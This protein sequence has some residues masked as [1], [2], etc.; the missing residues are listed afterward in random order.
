MTDG[1]RSRIISSGRGSAEEIVPIMS[2]PAFEGSNGY[3][4][5]DTP[6]PSTSGSAGKITILEDPSLE[7]QIDISI[8][9]SDNFPSDNNDITNEDDDVSDDISDVEILQESLPSTQMRRIKS[10]VKKGSLRQRN[11]IRHDI[12]EA[13]VQDSNAIDLTDGHEIINNPDAVD[14]GKFKESTLPLQ[15]KKSARRTMKHK[16][17]QVGKWKQFKFALS[18]KWDHLKSD[19]VDFFKNL[20]IWK[21]NLKAVEGTFGTGVLSYFLFLRWLF[22]LNIGI[23]VLML[24]FVIA[25]QLVYSPS[26][27]HNNVSFSG[28]EFLTG[29]GW[30]RN[31]EMYYGTYH[32]ETIRVSNTPYN[33]PFA[34]LFVGAGYILICVIVLVRSMAMSYRENYI[35]GGNFRNS[36]FTKIFCSWDYA[37][38]EK[39]SAVLQSKSICNDIV[40]SLDETRES[41]KKSASEICKLVLLRIWTN[42]IVIA[43]MAGASYLIYYVTSDKEIESIDS[44]IVRDLLP[45]ITISFLNLVLPFA[46]RII[47]SIEQYESAKTAVEISLFRTIV[48]K[49]SSLCVFVVAIYTDVTKIIKGT[50]K[51]PTTCWETWVGE[52]VYKLVIVDFIFIMSI[53]FFG[54]FVRR[55]FAAY[56]PSCDK[57]FGYPGFDISRNVLDLIYAQGICWLGTFFCPMLPIINVI[58]FFILFYFKKFSVLRNCRPSMRPF[59]ASMMNLIFLI[60]LGLILLLAVIVIGYAIMSGDTLKPS[61]TCGPFRGKENIYSMVTDVIKNDFGAVLKSII[62]IASSAAILAVIFFVLCLMAY[63]FRLRK[64]SAEKKIKLLK[65]QIAMTGK[66]KQYL[67]KEIRKI[68]KARGSTSQHI[69]AP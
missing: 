42:L 26:S 11:R 14:P 29:E 3:E 10:V 68:L 52:A 28:L 57:K 8:N 54:E 44:E 69:V 49:L 64:S 55:T 23:S 5:F 20:D 19:F 15:A 45:A 18:I 35:S 58:K 60:L 7:H 43:L 24:G 66:D 13:I 50:F 21:S 39:N 12:G 65:Q 4:S 30:F 1:R 61:A 62:D 47:A 34:Y 32:N 17:K 38:C 53:T 16:T 48:L 9:E 40:E 22:L 51:E 36:F 59:K 63:Y 2:N 56:V 67:S 27:K 31:T 41:L 37:I 6:K 33:L 46:F 25:P